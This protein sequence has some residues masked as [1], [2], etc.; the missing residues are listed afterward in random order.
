MTDEPVTTHYAPFA[1]W[2]CGKVMDAASHV[3]GKSV[4]KD[5]DVSVC[6]A[7]AEVMILDDGTWRRITDDELIEMPLEDKKILSGMQQLVRE[8]IRYR[9]EKKA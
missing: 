8:F 3:D 2:N 6:L 5:G 1:C 7:C 9:R 4:P